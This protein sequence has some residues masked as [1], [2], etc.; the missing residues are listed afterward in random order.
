MGSDSKKARQVRTVVLRPPAP[1]WERAAL[2]LT[3][4]AKNL[5]NTAT[6]LIRQINSAYERDEA[7]LYVRHAELHRNQHDAVAAFNMQIDRINDKRK[8]KEGAR[9]LPRLEDAMTASPL[10]VALDVTL[11]DNVARLWADADGDTVYRRL[12]AV[13]A[14]QVVRSVIDVWKAS[15][16]AMK[17]WT[18]NPA[19]YIG[20]PQFPSFK[21]KDGHFPLEVPFA[22]MTKGFPKPRVIPTLLALGETSPD[23]QERFYAHDLRAAVNRTCVARGWDEFVP[24]HVRLVE[25]AGRIRIEAV[26]AMAHSYPEGSFLKGLLDRHGEEMREHRNDG[27]RERFVLDLVKAALPDDKLHVAGIDFGETNVAAVA[28][29]TGHRAMVHSGQRPR[30]IVE[31][32]HALLDRRKAKLASPR[33]NELQRLKAELEERGEKLPKA[34]FVEYRREAGAAFRDPLHRNLQSR[35]DRIKSD[36]E[37]K[38]TTDIV[39]RCVKNGVSVIAVGRNKRMKAEKDWGAESNRKSHIFAHARLLAL[40]RYK[41][42]RHGIA[43]VTTEESYTSKTSFVDHDELRVFA[44]K[45]KQGTQTED[46]AGEEQASVPAVAYSGRRSASNRNWFIRQNAGSGRLTRVHADVNGA[47][48]IIRKVFS[49]FRYHAG[50][51]LKFDVRRI[52]PRLG[53]VAPLSCQSG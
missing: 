45:K 38:I 46:S 5:Y 22:M 50:L 8:D 52:S 41:A 14:Q 19:K 42:E 28:F 2:A 15:L 4:E 6:F 16:S 43:V 35:L 20:R 9:F 21:D 44:E 31:K 30:E 1:D 29:S 17:D 33:L 49:R 39:E 27:Q 37:H 34:E 13:C 11:L 24:Q 48:N 10:T 23:L 53:A 12:P 3:H 25:K 51:S 40:L 26:I 36:L 7:G 47:F 18:K 32:Y